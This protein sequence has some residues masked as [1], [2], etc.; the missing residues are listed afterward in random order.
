[1]TLKGGTSQA[2]AACKYQRRKCTSECLL[3]PYFPPHEQKI[4]QNAHKLFGV[5][6]ILKILKSLEPRHKDD[7]MRSIIYQS[8][9]RNE[10]PVYGCWGKINQLRYQ[11]WLAEEELHLV[12]NQLEIYRKHHQHQISSM[13]D[14]LTSQLDLGMAPPSNHANFQFYN[15]MTIPQSSYNA[16]P[17]FPLSEQH[18]QQQ[19]QQLQHASYSNSSNFV[20]HNSSAYVSEAKDNFW[21]QHPY[22]ATNDDS[23][24][25]DNSI[26]IHQQ[27]VQDFDER[28]FDTIDGRQSYID[29]S[30][31]AAYESRYSACMWLICYFDFI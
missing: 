16:M 15:H 8:N 31:E 11:I 10:N 1:M 24:N 5:S 14:D 19:Q 25:N 26:D 6:N 30:K 13:L 22:Y 17:T 12:L 3:A 9:I 2:C 23:N 21:I 29:N 28:F 27:V 7:A 20:V 18:H 4:F